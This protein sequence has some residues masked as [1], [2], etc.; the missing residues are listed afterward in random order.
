MRWHTYRYQRQ[1]SWNRYQIKNLK[2]ITYI[3]ND[4]INGCIRR[5]WHTVP[6]QSSVPSLKE[7]TKSSPEV[8]SCLP[9]WL[10]SVPG[11]CSGK[12]LHLPFRCLVPTPQ[13]LGGEGEESDP[14]LLTVLCCC[15]HLS[16]V[17]EGKGV[18][19]SCSCPNH[20]V[21]SLRGFT[22]VTASRPPAQF[23]SRTSAGRL[24]APGSRNLPSLTG[25]SPAAIAVSKRAS[26]RLLW[27]LMRSPPVPQQRAWSPRASL[28]LKQA[29]QGPSLVNT[30]S[31]RR[32]LRE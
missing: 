11:K 18:T 26:R 9:F 28:N 14:L 2:I 15:G 4:A 20:T 24:S 27:R 31:P 13:G 8:G 19:S 23:V 25:P 30:G 3:L 29:G 6:Q 17:G 22:T 12:L 32:Y 21:A 1:C 16:L 5:C 7:H 10:P